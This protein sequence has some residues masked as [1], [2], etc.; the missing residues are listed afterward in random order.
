MPTPEPTSP[1]PL[2]EIGQTLRRTGVI[3]WREL[4]GYFLSPIAY[5]V[6]VVFLLAAN[7][8]SLMGWSLSG[9]LGVEFF[10]RGRADL[11]PFFLNVPAL[12]VPLIAAITMRM[13]AEERQTGSLELLLTMPFRLGEVIV[14][15]VLASQIF[16]C[17]TLFLT[18]PLAMMLDIIPSANP[19]G[20]Q[21]LASYIGAA[22]L[23]GTFVAIGSLFSAMTRHQIVAFL[24][25]FFTTAAFVGIGNAGLLEMLKGENPG[26]SQFVESISAQTRFQQ[27]ARG[28]LDIGDI[29][30]FLAVVVLFLFLTYRVLQSKR[31]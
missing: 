31:A 12:F 11:E 19:D 6:T 10:E 30:F 18:F 1:S 14:G 27:I 21:I 23:G 25:T 7:I 4:R 26:L 5:A 29:T 2:A 9:D 28:V 24:V 3:V 20:G 22:I 13:W 17:I 16:V 8:A 15:K